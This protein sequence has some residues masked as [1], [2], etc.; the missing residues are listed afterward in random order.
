[1]TVD[2]HPLSAI[3]ELY[4]GS[5]IMWKD[6]FLLIYN[7]HWSIH[8]NICTCGLRKYLSYGI[9]YSIYL[10]EKSVRIIT[11]SGYYDYTNLIFGGLKI[12][13]IHDL[14]KY[15]NA[16]FMYNYHHGY[17]PENFNTFLIPV[18]QVH[19]YSTRA[20]S[21]LTYSLPQIRTMENLI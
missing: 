18:S 3:L 1:M 15:S 12:L 13:K 6:K 21:R 8:L 7:M 10:A 16:I 5:G 11:F 17:L 19:K 14:V 4:Q 20:A 2:T 9:G